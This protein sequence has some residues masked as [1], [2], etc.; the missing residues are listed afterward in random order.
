MSGARTAPCPR[1]GF[2][3][4]WDGTRCSH[5]NHQQPVCFRLSVTIDSV[6]RRVILL[7]DISPELTVAELISQLLSSL[8]LPPEEEG[9]YLTYQDSILH[10]E[11]RLRLCLP[12]TQELV[13]LV[14]V[15]QT[16]PPARLGAAR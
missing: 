1:C 8:D 4:G 11:S 7:E 5:C 9:W 3:Y 13:E 6:T 15:R 10:L 14:L 2:S 12:S 16:A